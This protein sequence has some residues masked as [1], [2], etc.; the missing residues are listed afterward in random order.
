[1]ESKANA[2]INRFVKIIAFY[3][4]VA[5]CLSLWLAKFNV[6]SNLTE[7]FEYVANILSYIVLVMVSYRYVFNSRERKITFFYIVFCVL[8]IVSFC[9]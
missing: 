8:I 9:I 7:I 5:I 3:S 4:M 1:M 2:K 6:F